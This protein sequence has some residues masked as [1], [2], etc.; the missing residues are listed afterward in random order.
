MRGRGRKNYGYNKNNYY[1]NKNYNNNYYYEGNNNNYYNNKHYNNNYDYYEGGNYKENQYDN[2]YNNNY[3]NGYNNNYRNDNQYYNKN[4]YHHNNKNNYQKK[5]MI[6]K[7]KIEIKKKKD[8]INYNDSNKKNKD[9]KEDD[10]IKILKDSIK[11]NEIKFLKDLSHIYKLEPTEKLFKDL[12]KK[13][14]LENKLKEIFNMGEYSPD[15]LYTSL[16]KLFSKEI[17]DLQKMNN[18]RQ[19]EEEKNLADIRNIY[20]DIYDAIIL[21]IQK[22]Y[23]KRNESKE[24][25]NSAIEEFNEL[26]NKVPDCL[27]YI[28]DKF[29]NI[30]NIE[31]ELK[32]NFTNFKNFDEFSKKY[33][34]NPILYIIKTFKLQDKFS[35]KIVCENISNLK[36]VIKNLYGTYNVNKAMLN[37]LNEYINSH[38]EKNSVEL[39][40]INEIFIINEN[41]PE[42]DKDIKKYIYDNLLYFD[43]NNFEENYLKKYYTF[44]INNKIESFHTEYNILSLDNIYCLIND[45]SLYETA[46]YLMGNLEKEKL[47]KIDNKLLDKII[48]NFRSDQK[49]EIKEFLDLFPNKIGSIITYFRNKDQLKEL[50][51]IL[52][53]AKKADKLSDEIANEI[54]KDKYYGI[55]NN[56]FKRNYQE[57]HQIYSIIEIVTK[58]KK[59]FNIFFPIL[60]K[61]IRKSNDANDV[62]LLYTVIDIAT[63]KNY[64]QNITKKYKYN[65]EDLIE[66]NDCFGP[67]TENCLSFKKDEINVVF[68]DS[69]DNLKL[70][71]EKYF[72]NSEFIGFDSEWVDK[73]KC[74]EKTETAIVQL[75]DYD[76][77][78]VLILDMVNLQKNNNF[79]NAFKEIFT[80]KKFIGYDLKD[81]LLNLPNEIMTHLQE[82]NELI[83]IQNLYKISTLESTKSFSEICKEFFGKP[84]CKYE[85]CSNWELRPL[86]QSQLHYAALD[87]IYCSLLF[88][89]IIEKK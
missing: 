19:N 62:K 85:Q 40:I 83:D 78:N 89:K 42:F 81:D 9:K 18:K 38:I 53:Y 41:N 29:I 22:D 7:T 50:L 30:Y 71:G 54:D 69:V 79:I 70:Y 15:K 8:F 31:N 77:K 82:K 67:Q 1:N 59:Y 4:N 47:D 3:N 39:I 14:T 80:G 27:F 88:K 57:K 58:S 49:K 28:L 2:N 74:K 43:K 11:T 35:F 63:K 16:F 76:G 32:E 36:E 10:E 17:E 46:L 68:I 75:S 86:R 60:E 44:L 25:K 37:E 56:K 24:I 13:E 66:L 51:A 52:K 26:V 64:N 73:I 61:I 23:I 72:K 12:F 55:L 45:Y 48:T 5:T 34:I 33:K 84:L 21:S 65:N 87:A 20:D 6:I